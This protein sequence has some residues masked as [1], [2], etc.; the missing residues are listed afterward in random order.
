M[1]GWLRKQMDRMGSPDLD[2][3]QV[4]VTTFCNASCF[5]CPHAVMGARWE[6]RHMSPALFRELL[7]FLGNTGLVFL[8]GWG[9]PLLNGALFD[10][11]RLC[12]DQGNRVG[13][14]TNGMLLTEGTTKKLLDLEPDIL[15]VSLAGTTP[16]IH[17]R[18]RTGTDLDK[19]LRNL[20]RLREMKEKGERAVPEVH[21][22][23]LVVRSNFDD[24]KQ[25]VPLA[26]R[27]GARE[28]VASN[29]SL[30]LN[31]DL[32]K[33]P[34]FTDAARCNEYRSVFEAI[35][36]DAQGKGIH[37][38]FNGPA[39]N[40]GSPRCRENIGRACVITVRGEV[41]PCVMTDPL[42]CRK[43]ESF[44]GEAPYHIFRGQAYPLKEMCFG[45][46]GDETL[47]RIWNRRTYRAFRDLFK[48]QKKPEPGAIL[49]K[50]P[51]CCLNCYKRLLE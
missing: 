50:L 35:R 34:L 49:E 5:Y 27:V 7:P 12:K 48:A 39:L 1:L 14:T 16:E 43:G 26:E 46:I 32:F 18:I 15:G 29:L 3:V 10:M 2:W 22:A 28:V 17:N 8:Q 23:Y 45:R 24:L 19:I 6:N 9:E 38:A 40:E 47:P 36:K 20:E 4:E 44:E 41:V 33:E 42:L 51:P 21:L 13:F 37:F 30:V 31:R 25:I 11:I